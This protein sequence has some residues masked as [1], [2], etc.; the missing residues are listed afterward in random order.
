MPWRVGPVGAPCV[1]LPSRSSCTTIS[2]D[3]WHGTSAHRNDHGQRIDL[4]CA[5]DMEAVI[6]RVTNGGAKSVTL[7]GSNRIHPT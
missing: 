5:A 4:V 1:A 6:G 3:T 2:Q 7:L